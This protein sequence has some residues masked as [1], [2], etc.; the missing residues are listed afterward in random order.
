MI[1][2]EAWRGN[3]LLYRAP[4]AGPYTDPEAAEPDRLRLEK[5]ERE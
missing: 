5:G 1:W 3:A 2:R 4:C